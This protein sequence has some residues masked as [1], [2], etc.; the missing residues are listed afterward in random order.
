[1]NVKEDDLLIDQLAGWWL[2]AGWLAD[3]RFGWL[4][5]WLTGW[6]ASWLASWL[7]D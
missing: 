6:P 4:A 3:W 2:V 7:I 5:S 1:M